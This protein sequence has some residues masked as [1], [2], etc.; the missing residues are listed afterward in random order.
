MDEKTKGQQPVISLDAAKKDE[1]V[2]RL[3][4]QKIEEQQF[5][6]SAAGPVAMAP[7]PTIKISEAERLALPVLTAMACF[8][9]FVLFFGVYF[10][11]SLIRA[12]SESVIL[13]NSFFATTRQSGVFLSKDTKNLSAVATSG[14]VAGI[15]FLGDKISDVAILGAN[16]TVSLI[17]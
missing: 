1:L 2:E 15:N 16:K 6:D 17:E 7:A 14:C 11:G 5:A 4:R 12:Q 9:A 13:I 3:F 8:V 10:S